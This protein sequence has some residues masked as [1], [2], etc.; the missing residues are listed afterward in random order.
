MV[1]VRAFSLGKLASSPLL[2][3]LDEAEGEGEE[4][5][6]LDG[7]AG[8]AAALDEEADAAVSAPTIRTW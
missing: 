2:D 5:G 8:R 1:T 6:E 3:E 4:D 7:D